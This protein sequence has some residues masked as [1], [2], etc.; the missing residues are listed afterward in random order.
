MISVEVNGSVLELLKYLLKT[1]VLETI[2]HR[3]TR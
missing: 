2:I 3:N 1:Y